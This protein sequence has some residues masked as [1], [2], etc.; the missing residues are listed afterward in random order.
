MYHL[1]FHVDRLRNTLSRM[2]SQHV[3][4]WSPGA[5]PAARRTF[6]TITS[7]FPY[8]IGL[9]EQRSVPV[10]HALGLKHGFVVMKVHGF[11]TVNSTSN[12][13]RLFKEIRAKSSECHSVVRLPRGCALLSVR[14]LTRSS[15]NDRPSWRIDLRE[16]ST[17]TI[18]K[19]NDKHS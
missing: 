15:T 16:N 5:V 1:L 8:V 14:R 11:V 10:F 2:Y 12:V 13:R 6:N 4:L 7:R 3:Q 9:D 17:K 18:N 19:I